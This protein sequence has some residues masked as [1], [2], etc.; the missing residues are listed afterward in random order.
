MTDASI[1]EAL[2]GVNKLS[3]SQCGLSLRGSKLEPVFGPKYFSRQTNVL[4]AV[5]FTG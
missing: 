1:A 5:E 4:A 3:D 2:G